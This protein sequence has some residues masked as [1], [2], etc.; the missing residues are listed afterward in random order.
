MSRAGDFQARTK[1]ALDQ[2]SMVDGTDR[3]D[4]MLQYLE[5]LQRWNRTYNLTAVREPEGMLT[6]HI[7]D[8]LAVVPWLRSA[9]LPQ[10][11]HVADMGSGAGLPG[12]ILAICQPDWQITCVDAV[13]KK[14]VFIRQAAGVLG[15]GN[16]Q[17]VH[18]RIEALAPLGS[19]LIVSRAFA[20]LADYARL[21]APHLAESGMML[22]MK[23][24]F[25]ETE[26]YDLEHTT[27]W[28]VRE[29]VDL[30]VPELD[31]RR[32]LIRLGSK[33]AHAR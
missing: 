7:F 13:E 10:H 21:C 11:T 31:A 9:G 4:R 20:S 18:G 28:C 15:L 25:P 24:H 14:T 6:Q 26:Q 30:A 12:I 5:L 16:V 17:V 3:I 22:A 29:V 27:D 1:A 2:L 23:G 32:C 19:D 33:E 8:S